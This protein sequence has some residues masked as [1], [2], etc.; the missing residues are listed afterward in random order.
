MNSPKIVPSVLY[1]TAKEEDLDIKK[2]LLLESNKTIAELIES[3]INEE[4]NQEQKNE[5]ENH[6]EK[7]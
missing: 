5:K 6:S 7:S 4:K 3:K 1:V 2:D